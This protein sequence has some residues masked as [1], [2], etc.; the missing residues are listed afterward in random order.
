MSFGFKSKIILLLLPCSLLIGLILP[1]SAMDNVDNGAPNIFEL[2]NNA[3]S[4]EKYVQNEL[5]VKFNPGVSEDKIKSFNDKHGT[6]V[7]YTSPYEKFKIV[8]IPPGK[9][10]EEMVEVYT[11]NS[12]VEYAVPNAIDYVFMTPNDRYYPLQWNFKE[13]VNGI[14]GGINVEPAWDIS[15]GNGVIVAVIDT[16][17]AYENNGVYK[18]APDFENTYFVP[19]YDFVNNDDHPNDDNAHGTHVAG[20]VAQSTNNNYGVAGIAYGCSIMPVKVLDNQGSG[21]LQQLVDGIYFATDQGAKVISMSL[22]FKPGYNP[23]K[24]LAHALDYAYGKGVTIVAAAGNDATGTVCYPAADKKCISVGATRFDGSLAPYSNYGSAIDVVAPGGDISVDQNHDN[25]P[26][27]IL[28]NTFTPGNPSDFSKWW[29]YEGT[30]MATP[31]VSGIAALII[32]NKAMPPAQVKKAIE[33]TAI[34]L[35][36]PS[37]D[38]YYGYGLVNAKAALDYKTSAS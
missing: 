19:G 12:D 27:G 13:F 7:T 23:G 32:S 21:T 28:Q 4:K 10:V 2:A 30:S 34:D 16:G 5:L 26:D 37:W 17:V 9:T 18:K 33:N 1:V 6:K 22:G 36:D 25:V 11:K 31:H 38:M 15:K 3:H 35:G 14:G 8:K 29:L 24:P 20:T